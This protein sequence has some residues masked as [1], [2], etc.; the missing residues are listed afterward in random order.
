ML[1]DVMIVGGGPTGLM[2]AAELRLHGV[3]TVVLEKEA[4]P[5]R[6]V[7]ALGLHVRSIEVMAQRGLLERFLAHGKQF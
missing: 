4:E 1:I 7:R 6:Y 3:R 2:L 5:A